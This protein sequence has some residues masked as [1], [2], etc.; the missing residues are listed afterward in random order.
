MVCPRCWGSKRAAIGSC[1]YCDG[2]GVSADT[3]LS[4]HLRLSEMLRSQDAARLLIPND[5]TPDQIKC[6]TTFATN[7]F[8]PA[9]A[10]VGLLHVDSGY[11]SPALNK[12]VGGAPDSEHMACNAGDLIPK[13]MRLRDAIMKIAASS[14]RFDELILEYSWMHLAIYGPG[15][16]QRRRVLQAFAG[17]PGKP[18]CTQFNPS[19][20]RVL[21]A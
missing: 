17:P 15:K 7:L 1:S 20:P 8:E 16:C 9:R 11:R 2:D 13:T 21:A 14:L 3:T 18:E 5:V 10:L 19:D 4:T 6:L 12:A